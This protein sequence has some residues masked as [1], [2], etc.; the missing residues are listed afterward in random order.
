MAK[1]ITNFPKTV[2]KAVK[3]TFKLDA[4]AVVRKQ[5]NDSLHNNRDAEGKQQPEK[6]PRTKQ[7][8]A[9]EGWDQNNWLVR[10]G[11]STELEA[12]ITG[13]GIRIQP[14]GVDILS[15]PG[16]REYAE[17]WFTLNEDTQQELLNKIN[18]RLK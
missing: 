17:N 16:L 6:K 15:K 18:E 4:I 3:D 7:L 12:T 13:N 9:K 5:L 1:L 2:S 14:K 11:Q 8:Y 10:T